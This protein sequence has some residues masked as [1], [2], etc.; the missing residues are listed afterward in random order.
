MPK[1]PGHREN[2]WQPRKTGYENDKAFIIDKTQPIRK[3]DG[4]THLP[5]NVFLFL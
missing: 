1:Q 5:V 4:E 3:A 2:N